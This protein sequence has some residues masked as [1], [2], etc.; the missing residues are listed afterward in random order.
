[1]TDPSGKVIQLG[2]LGFEVSDLLA[3]ERFSTRVL[4]LVMS[5][6]TDGGG[7][8][9]GMDDREQRFFLAPGP[10][11]DLA[12]MGLAVADDAALDDLSARIRSAGITIVEG[13]AEE[14]AKRRV[15]RLVK[16]T[17]PAGTPLEL[18]H[19]QAMAETPFQSSVV[20]AGFVAGD[21]GLGHAVIT[22]KSR[23]ESEAFY[24]N[25]LGF[26]LSDHVVCD[27]HG[28]AVN[29]GFFHVAG[30]HARHHSLALGEGQRKRIHH[31]L[32]EVRSMDEVGLGFDRAWKSGLRI[33]QTL[34]RHPNDRM[35]SFYAKTPS[36]FQF[37][38]GWGGREVDDATWVPTTYDRISEWGHHPPTFLA[39]PPP[40]AKE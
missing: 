20:R 18:F 11:D 13:T 1:M 22:A 24:E 23:T 15:K 35:F 5:R 3:W 32:I 16:L 34:G 12:F 36:G 10:A 4:G 27:V 7:F 40:N 30:E 19:G 26:R 38:M 17:D 8:T 37:E 39:N 28:H 31:F 9:L 6:R 2:Y 21:L 25:L 33:M 14:A 29:I